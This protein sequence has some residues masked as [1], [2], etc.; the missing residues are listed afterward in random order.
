MVMGKKS[1]RFAYDLLF[2]WINILKLIIFPAKNYQRQRKGPNQVFKGGLI[3]E[4]N[5]MSKN[6]QNNLTVQL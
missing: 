2:F 4:V 3:S 1:Q 6:V 5:P